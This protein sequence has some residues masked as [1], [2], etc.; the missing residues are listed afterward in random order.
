MQL[1]PVEIETMISAQSHKLIT[2]VSVAGVSGRR[3]LDERVSRAWIVLSPAGAAL[4]E[5]APFQS[6][7]SSTLWKTK[8]HTPEKF[9]T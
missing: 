6:S 3:T 5:T 9:H 4:G 7:R 8:K 2:D 1:Y